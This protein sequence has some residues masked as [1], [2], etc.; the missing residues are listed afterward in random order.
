[1]EISRI[2]SDH[3]PIDYSIDLAE[4]SFVD[5]IGQIWVASQSM[6]DILVSSSDTEVVEIDTLDELSGR[7][8]FG[9]EGFATIE[10]LVSYRG[11]PV[12]ISLK[13]FLVGNFQVQE[14]EFHSG[15]LSETQ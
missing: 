8:L 6:V 12:A 1:M 11:N 3:K 7:F 15:K 4:I 2:E 13:H 5:E 14:F 9:K 10:V